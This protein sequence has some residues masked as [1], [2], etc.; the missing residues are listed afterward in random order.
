MNNKPNIPKLIKKAYLILNILKKL[1]TFFAFNICNLVAIKDE[2][3][4]NINI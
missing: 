4:P 1:L 3:N 2:N